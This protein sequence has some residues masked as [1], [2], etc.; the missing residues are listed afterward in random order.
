MSPS[1]P[2]PSPRIRRQQ[3]LQACDTNS[4]RRVESDDVNETTFLPIALTAPPVEFQLPNGGIVRLPLGV[5]QAA[6]IA[7]I[8]AAG[9]CGHGR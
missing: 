4:G 7:A 5:G 8:E 2:P 3:I 6:L 9:S 1:P